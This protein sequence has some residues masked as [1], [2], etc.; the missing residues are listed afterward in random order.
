MRCALALLLF[1]PALASAKPKW[2]GSDTRVKSTGS[3]EPRQLADRFADVVNIL[4]FGA[5]CDNSTDD[6]AEIQAAVDR[7]EAIGGGTLVLP[8]GTCKISS[9]IT[10]DGAITVKGAGRENTVIDNTANGHAFDSTNDGVNERVVSFMDFTIKS[11]L[12]GGSRTAGSAIHIKGPF[13]AT[14]YV[15]R[16]RLKDHYNGLS[17]EDHTNVS[18]D[19]V[20]SRDNRNDG[21]Q[22]YGSGPTTT[23]RMTACYASGNTRYGFYVAGVASFSGNLL[24]SE[25]SG[26]DNF[27]FASGDSITLISPYSEAAPSTGSAFKFDSTARVL[28][29]TPRT[30]S[31]GID[32]MELAAAVQAPKEII[33]IGGNL[34]GGTGYGVRSVNSPGDDITLIGVLL[35]G[36]SGDT[37]DPG[38]NITKIMD[39]DTSAS[40]L[41]GALSTGGSLT[42]NGGTAISKYVCG[43]P[44]TWDPDNLNDGESDTVQVT[45]TGA[46]SGDIALVSL[47]TLTTQ[48]MSL[49]GAVDSTNNVTVTL[50]NENGGAVNI[51]SGTLRACVLKH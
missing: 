28:I 27:H 9:P 12:A 44:T 20:L 2:G 7:L 51:T 22:V 35:S 17:L 49:T 3:T 8:A 4:D 23:V 25:S 45:V 16:M 36:A 21:F 14:A 10:V 31:T 38:S 18:V 43:T 15:A 19:H 39:A 5:K 48:A 32:G 6:T 40:T 42:I 47:T 29:T 50:I 11:S 13:R 26:D 33:V 46:A 30:D 37:L 1:V 34:G 24:I 41:R